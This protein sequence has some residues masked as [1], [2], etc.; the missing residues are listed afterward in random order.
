MSIFNYVKWLQIGRLP[1]I[2]YRETERDSVGIGK[3]S[4]LYK[5]PFVHEIIHI[6]ILRLHK[7]TITRSNIFKH[8]THTH[9]NINAY[10]YTWIKRM[11]YNEKTK[12]N[13]EYNLKN[14][15]ST[16]AFWRPQT[17][18]SSHGVTHTSS[19]KCPRMADLLVH[20]LFDVQV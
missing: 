16:A 4:V 20:F 7:G 8:T 13:F 1:D 14:T 12:Q 19:V 18:A 6:S 2:V 3:K 10:R 17:F 15:E 5:T 9:I 11:V